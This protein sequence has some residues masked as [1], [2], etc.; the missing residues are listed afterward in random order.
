M[1]E[2]KGLSRFCLLLCHTI[3]RPLSCGKVDWKGTLSGIVGI[4]GLFSEI[5]SLPTDKM[6]KSSSDF[7]N[8]IRWEVCRGCCLHW[9]T[10]LIADDSCRLKTLTRFLFAPFPSGW[11][12]QCKLHHIL[13]WRAS[14]WWMRHA[15]VQRSILV[16]NTWQLKGW[17]W[18][19]RLSK[20][21]KKCNSFFAVLQDLPGWLWMGRWLFVWRN[22][23]LLSH[24]TGSIAIK[25]AIVTDLC[26]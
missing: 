18:N 26:L 22:M 24:L 25:R 7:E 8:L 6:V 19:L 11:E 10:I 5:V 3:A 21:V 1:A 23:V 15:G 16:Y 4:M 2:C 17:S 20:R 13:S 12:T 9:P 14:F